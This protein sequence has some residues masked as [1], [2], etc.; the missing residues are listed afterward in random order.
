MKSNQ[1]MLRDLKKNLDSYAFTGL[2]SENL[3]IGTEDDKLSSFNDLSFRI[4][5]PETAR[6][7]YA[8][9]DILQNIVD[10]PAEDATR[11]GFKLT[12]SLDEDGASKIILE[13]LEELKINK[14]LE[15][16]LKNINMYSEGSLVIPIIR[17]SFE[18][19][20][21]E[22]LSIN[23]I[24]RIEGINVLDED[25]FSLFVNNTEP[26]D[27]NYHKIDRVFIR[28]QVIH[29][30]RFMWDAY[31]YFPMENQGVSKLQKVLL[32]CLALRI[33]T[34]S[35]STVMIEVQNKVLKVADLDSYADQDNMPDFANTK[36]SKRT[37]VINKMKRWMTSSKMLVI[38]KDDSYERQMYNVTGLKETTDFLFQYLSAVSKQS[39]A[40]IKGQAL[41]TISGSDTD[42]KQY[43]SKLRSDEQESRSRPIIEYIINLIK[44]EK[45]GKYYKK[46]GLLGTQINFKLEFNQIWKADET[47]NSVNRLRDSQRGQVD[48][49][50]G[51]RSADQVQAELYPENI[52]EPLPE[53][54]ENLTAKEIADMQREHQRLLEF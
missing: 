25:D 24:E 19:H 15:K 43:A 32:A 9:S 47:E 10:M 20:N 7:I 28:G 27:I 18:N 38:D 4:L 33:T 49:S 34:W 53:M 6:R 37:L 36:T 31:K 5:Q 8:N 23:A 44:N 26:L 21:D 29:P 50:T 35:L 2:V 52:E 14:I 46:F 1:K 22:R 3:G 54:P 51:V 42:A 41:G 39:Q 12:S 11:E 16:H 45:Q 40:S 30:S 17:E 48:I 13:R